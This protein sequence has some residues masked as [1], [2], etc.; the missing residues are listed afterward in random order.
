MCIKSL[1]ELVLVGFSWRG[2]WPGEEAVDQCHSFGARLPEIYSTEDNVEILNLKVI[3]I[4]TN[5]FKKCALFLLIENSQ[6]HI[7]PFAIELVTAHYSFNTSVDNVVF[8]KDRFANQ[9]CYNPPISMFRGN[10]FGSKPC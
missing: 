3:F 8:P 6:T 2:V 1:M 9:Y 5:L 7:K 10:Q 4:A